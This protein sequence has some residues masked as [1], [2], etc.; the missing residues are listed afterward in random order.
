MTSASSSPVRPRN[1]PPEA[2]STSESTLLLACG[3]PALEG[4]G[5][6]AVDR[7]QPASSPLL[8]REREVAGGDEALL[9][10]E[11]E[12][13]AALERP[14]RH[15]QP[16]EADDRVQDDVR[17][18]PL[19]QLG[20]VAARPGSAARAR[21]SACEPDAAA[22]SSRPGCASTISIAW[23]PI[24]PVAPIRATRFTE[25]VLLPVF[26]VPLSSHSGFR[27]VRIASIGSPRGGGWVHRSAP[28]KTGPKRAERDLV[29]LH[30]RPWSAPW[31]AW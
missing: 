9:V 4:G 19:E 1:G 2:V 31:S 11:R 10:R 17:L 28:N 25:T 14:E 24:E 8:R 18:G 13:D 6:L 26:S 7:E 20:Q 30:R 3:P 16:G 15:G 29:L 21:R 23:R 27:H 5:V 12:V 22:T